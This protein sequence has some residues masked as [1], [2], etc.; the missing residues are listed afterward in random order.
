V[1]DTSNQGDVVS[2]ESHSRSSPKTQSTAR[3]FI[4]DLFLG[5]TDTS[6]QAFED[7]DKGLTMRF[8]SSQEAQHAL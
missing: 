4:L 7:H 1:T 6:R 3:E 2:L 5:D 8:T